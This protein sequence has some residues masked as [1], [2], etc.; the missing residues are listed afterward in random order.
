MELLCSPMR[1][2][3]ND[4]CQLIYTK[5]RGVIY[6]FTAYLY[7]EKDIKANSN[8]TIVTFFEFISQFRNALFSDN[9]EEFSLYYIAEI[10]M[11]TVVERWKQNCSKTLLC[12]SSNIL[13]HYEVEIH[14]QITTWHS[15]L[16][17]LRIVSN[18][19]ISNFTVSVMDTPFHFHVEERD[20]RYSESVMN[21]SSFY[22]D[23]C[24]DQAEEIRLAHQKSCPLVQLRLSDYDWQEGRS[25]INFPSLDINLYGSEF[26]F[27]INRS[28]I[29]ICSNTYKQKFLSKIQDII[30]GY[31]VE[32][33]LSL[34]CVSVSLV[35]LS[36]SF[37]TFCLFPRL[38][39]LPG[40]TN[41][42]LIM[43]LLIAQTM[44]LISS[45]SRLPR[46]SVECKVM[47]LLTHF[48][49]LMATFWMN[50][51]TFHVFKIFTNIGKVGAD[52]GSL[53]TFLV[54]WFYSLVLSTSLVL[55]NIF[56]SLRR[57]NNEDFGYGAS[58]C[59]ISSETMI[60]FTFGIPLGVVVIANLTMFL[61]TVWQLVKMPDIQK[62]V[63]NKRNDV[64]IFTKLSTLT[65]FTW[66]FGFIFS[67]TGVKV[68]S[69]LFILLNAS[70]GVFL[71]LSF[72]CNQ[73][74]LTMYKTRSFGVTT[75][76]SGS[77]RTRSTETKFRM[78]SQAPKIMDKTQEDV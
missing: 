55:V 49:W 28:T 67:W 77:Y 42:S 60:G 24:S 15:L 64:I 69:Y 52:K 47:G 73:R 38:R 3:I 46:E 29:Y 31:D 17:M 10:C 37:I 75:T 59:Y 41:M 78:D 74:V 65:G 50:I 76:S 36:I 57:S 34:V 63:K 12:T 30:E 11:E 48:F 9:N 44:F 27:G 51:C 8:D 16:D 58:S 62:D 20:I 71:F 43:C 21:D 68:F 70:Q 26:H 54:Y 53:K 25:G 45:Y 32:T 6:I 1:N 2:L 61:F 39:T 66:V 13:D 7:P 19:S 56:I 22:F 4:T 14:I 72:V 33:L 5:V 18:M 35:C 23:T 40:K